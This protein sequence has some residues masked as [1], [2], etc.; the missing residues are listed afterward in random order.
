MNQIVSSQIGPRL[1]FVGSMVGRNPGHIT[2]QGY[3]L[4]DLFKQAGYRVTSVSA[5]LNRYRRLIDILS[6]LFKQRHETDILVIEIYGGPS[7]VVEDIA[8]R[9]GERFGQRIIMWLHGGALPEFITRH[10]EWAR[11]V[12]G[13]AHAIVTPSEFLARTV[14]QHG[15]EAR[16]IANVIDLPFY[17]YRHRQSVNP[18]LFWMRNFHSI[19]NPNMAVRALSRLRASIP[20]ANLVMAGPDKGMKSEVERFAD[21]LG[22]SDHIRFPGFLDMD[23]KAREGSAADIYINT[24]RID[25]TPVAVVEACAMGLPVVTTCVGG[26]PDML[27]HGETALFVDDDDDEAM[28]KA[29]ENLINNPNLASLLSRNGQKLAERFSWEQVRPQWEQ[30]FVELMADRKAKASSSSRFA[31]GNENRPAN[32]SVEETL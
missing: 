6:T 29:I 12:L 28:A 8:S 2:Q 32:T 13:R 19:W 18:R 30:M 17:P 15:F 31:F 20:E 26:I 4:S 14:A 1:C 11:R 22:L 16:I 21:E 10:P 25:N 9:I 27:K 7:F 3:V 23:G 24:N 5:F